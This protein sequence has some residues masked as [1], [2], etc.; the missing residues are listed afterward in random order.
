MRKVCNCLLLALLIQ[1]VASCGNLNVDEPSKVYD[2]S[3]K[4]LTI[5]TGAPS[6]AKTILPEALDSSSLTYYF[7]IDDLINDLKTL[8]IFDS[9]SAGTFLNFPI[10]LVEGYYKI[11]VYALAAAAAAGYSKANYGKPTNEGGFGAGHLAT[12]CVMWGSATVD[13]RQDET[14]NIALSAN[15]LT[16]NVAVA[17]NFFTSGWVFDPGKFNATC[18]MQD[19]TGALI[20]TLSEV[21]LN[22]VTSV[23]PS[24]DTAAVYNATVPAGTYTFFVKYKKLSDASAVYTWTDSIIVLPNQPIKK[25]IALPDIIEHAPAAPSGLKAS[26]YDIDPSGIY[27]YVN[28]SWTDNSVNEAGFQIDLKAVSPSDDDALITSNMAASWNAVN[29]DLSA[30]TG[31]FTRTAT[32][33]TQAFDEVPGLCVDGSLNKNNS[34]A[35]FKLNRNRRYLAR[36]R[37]I[38]YDH[39]D[40]SDWVY[41]DFTLGGTGKTGYSAFDPAAR[42]MKVGD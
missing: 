6:V 32:A 8:Q 41:V 5:T 10:E 30:V 26:Y 35:T 12:A 1:V 16:G 27:C 25:N 28:F 24:L 18:G 9:A 40:P 17:L 14:I 23:E 31:S 39:A 7:A 19:K 15:N 29:S 34:S 38:G 13:L 20:G 2:S 21:D 33:L 11:R 42:Y 4:T 36:I 37:S 3:I 22:G